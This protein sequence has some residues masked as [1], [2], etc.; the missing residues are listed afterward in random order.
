MSAETP[1][2]SN[3]GGY[4]NRAAKLLRLDATLLVIETKQNLQS[5]AVT[6]G[7]LAAAM[8][9]SFL[10]LVVLLFAIVLLLV[11]LGVGADLASLLV[12]LLLF[13]ASGLMVFLGVQRLRSS[14]FKPHRTMAQFQ[15][16]IE[17][18]R[19]SL[20]HEPNPNR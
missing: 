7:L 17:A 9:V 12:A 11:H 18:L 16:N 15:T 14:T 20:H 2:L 8:A 4:V 13:A 6:L 1:V 19:A 5:V 3:L 10:G